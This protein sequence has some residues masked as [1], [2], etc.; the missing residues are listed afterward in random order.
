MRRRSGG[1]DE[2]T[3]CSNVAKKQV[4]LERGR[5]G[6]IAADASPER[7]KEKRNSAKLTGCKARYHRPRR[8]QRALHGGQRGHAYCTSGR[9]S[10]TALDER[11][12]IAERS[13]T[14]G[15]GS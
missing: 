10:L 3:R 9:C 15:S 8:W 2:T 7:K 5:E 12:L 11:G 4:M 13:G 1:Q 6:L 14:V